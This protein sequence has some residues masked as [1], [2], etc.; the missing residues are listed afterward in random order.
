MPFPSFSLG[1]KLVW[2]NK[3]RFAIV[4][5]GTI[6]A[7]SIISSVFLVSN[8]QGYKIGYTMM[9]E[10]QPP[11]YIN[12]QGNTKLN[13]T[14]YGQLDELIMEADAL[15]THV[16]DKINR[17]CSMTPVRG[18]WPNMEIIYFYTKASTIN[19]SSFILNETKYETLV[20]NAYD[21]FKEIETST[22]IEGSIP[23]ASKEIVISSSIAGPN[24][25]FIGD[26]LSIVNNQTREIVTGY[27]VVG[28]Y[29]ESGSYYDAIYMQFNDFLEMIEVTGGSDEIEVAFLYEPIILAYVDLNQVN[30]Y[31]LN[32]IISKVSLLK[33]RIQT[34]LEYHNYSF[35]IYNRLE[36]MGDMSLV[37]TLFMLMQLGIFIGMLFPIIQLSSY[38][39]RTINFEVFE[40]REG[41]FAQ[42]RSR[43]F[44]RK[45][46]NKVLGAEILVSTGVCAVVTGLL[47]TGLFYLFQPMTQ[48]FMFFPIAP[49]TQSSIENPFSSIDIFLIFVAI[50]TLLSFLFILVLYIQPMQLS[51]HKELIDSLKE[52]IKA[53]QQERNIVGGIVSMF[54]IGGIPLVLYILLMI[55]PP[56]NI[57]SAALSSINGIIVGFTIAAPFFLSLAFIK[58]LGEKKSG[59]LGRFCTSLLP[60]SQSPLKHV[61]LRNISARS[62]KVAKLMMIIAFT[63]AFG[64]TVRVSRSSLVEYRQE[65]NQILL[66]ADIRA[67]TSN[68]FEE[69]EALMH[70]IKS[71][72]NVSAA[73]F[74]LGTFGQIINLPD[75]IF[76]F[77]M[78]NF[79]MTNVSDVISSSTRLD[80]KYL[81]G[82]TWQ[83]ISD[84]ANINER[85]ALLPSFLADKV[86]NTTIVIR[87]EMRDNE[88]G[89]NF[90]IIRDYTIAGYFKAF[91]GIDYTP[92]TNNFGVTVYP[93]ILHDN[94]WTSF[95]N[96]NN[97]ISMITCIKTTF[98]NQSLIDNAAESMN[99][100]NYLTMTNV[101]AFNPLS[102][103]ILLDI[104]LFF[105]LLDLDFWLSLAISI[106][107]I[108]IIT[109]MRI[110]KE[111]KEIGLF[112]VRGFDTRMMYKIELAEKF[113]PIVIAASIGIVAGMFSSLVVIYGTGFN[114][115]P[116]NFTLYYPLNIVLS[117]MDI[118]LLIVLPITLYFIVI[119]L[120]IRFEVRQ[121][122]GSIMDEDD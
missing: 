117:L 4:M 8:N 101:G 81:F 73:S 14:M 116:V 29:G 114:F 19:W 56:G 93:I 61:I 65:K 74:F 13:L 90:F 111:R 121:H 7:I 78:Y 96:T 16:V 31:N 62:T 47:G 52:K 20:F 2:R 91:P 77:N 88:T 109:F 79:M 70:D 72:E 24:A 59:T 49:S 71:N 103:N 25:L 35:I 22:V 15:G 80:N 110:T 76:I 102:F 85:I 39:S 97:S 83:T 58:L 45:Q 82:T 5:S 54:L 100:Q 10:M 118:F 33:D 108:G 69:H 46:M 115:S 122:L 68:I 63:V 21:D 94:P 40:R 38:V 67:S 3:R 107:G 1:F 50:V 84:H 92:P 95:N 12:P 112:R 27:K 86:T 119:L 11:L 36:Y 32:E 42:F 105:S 44:S 53:R 51:Y 34:G 75:Q 60:R 17:H 37:I 99:L 55:L 28:I 30:I 66:G 106:F 113:V 26:L 6:L 89:D 87:I 23:T 48:G 120:A 9:K 57:F 41:E 43:G 98:S 64:F 18:Y 104:P